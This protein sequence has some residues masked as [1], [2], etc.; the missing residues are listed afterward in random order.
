M[1]TYG[2]SRVFADL[3]NI[4]LGTDLAEY[5]TEQIARCSAF[6]VLIGRRLLS[7]DAD[8]RRR[9]DSRDDWV[10]TEIRAALQ[11]NIP[12]IPVLVENASMPSAPELPEDLRPLA[13]RQAIELRSEQWTRDV[14]RLIVE[15]MA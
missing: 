10:R 3:E 11:Q 14:E 15:S 13:S 6:L 7:P 2:Q 5:V 1:A 8:G 9:I 4:P 12:V